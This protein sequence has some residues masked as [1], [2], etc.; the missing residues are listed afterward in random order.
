[1]T[2]RST[3]G[4]G[5]GNHVGPPVLLTAP[6]KLTLSLR[7][8]GLL[9]GGMHTLDAE[10]VTLDFHDTL[11]VTGLARSPDPSRSTV[12]F[13]ETDDV[14]NPTDNL[15]TQALVLAQRTARVVVTKRIPAGAGLGGG[16]ADAAAILRWAGFHDQR[17]AARRLGADVAFCL[18]GGRAQVTGFG[19]L[20]EPRPFQAVQV[21]LATP[22]VRCATSAVFQ[23]WDRLGGPQ[24][25]G[26]ND[27][28]LAALAVAP[29]LAA[30]REA[31]GDDTG[32]QPHLAGSGST[33]FVYGAHPGP[34]RVVADAVPPSI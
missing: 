23:A 25:P 12:V 10:M 17:E 5:A 14:I 4:D 29:E 8:T 3:V 28:E 26:M 27:L 11:A 21:T 32:E 19:D 9:D 2:E 7:I 24:G 20:V 31:L 13:E 18:V 34:G 33:W 30:W 1:V 16:S 22:P 15:V 6:A